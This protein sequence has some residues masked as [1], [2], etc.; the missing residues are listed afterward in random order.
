MPLE[1]DLQAMLP[2]WDTIRIPVIVIQGGKDNL[3][4]PQN[5]DFAEQVLGSCS[6][7]LRLPEAGHFIL[8][9]QPGVIR[10]AILTLLEPDD[11]LMENITVCALRFPLPY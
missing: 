6:Q 3:V 8:W 1:Q 7:I 10:N 9:K 4:S 2:L 11:T 5:A